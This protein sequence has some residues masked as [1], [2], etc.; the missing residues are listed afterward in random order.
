VQRC[1]QRISVESGA[2]QTPVFAWCEEV[3]SSM[4][5]RSMTPRQAHPRTPLGESLEKTHGQI[6]EAAPTFP[7]PGE[8]LVEGLTNTEEGTFLAAIADA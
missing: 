6:L 2:T 4:K 7:D 5:R 8:L 1:D 3:T